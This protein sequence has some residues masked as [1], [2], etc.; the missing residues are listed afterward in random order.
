V[1]LRN[2]LRSLND[3]SRIIIIASHHLD[4][5]QRIAD[6]V[7]LIDQGRLLTTVDPRMFNA[8]DGSLEQVFQ[9]FTSPRSS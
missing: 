7:V 8:N 6:S 1:D 2:H 9:S 4:E 5:L 3:G